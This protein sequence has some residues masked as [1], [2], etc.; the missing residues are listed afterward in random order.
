[1]RICIAPPP[2]PALRRPL[3]EPPAHTHLLGTDAIMSD[4]SDKKPQEAHKQLHRRG[5]LRRARVRWQERAA[6]P[7][8]RPAAS[9]RR[10]PARRRVLGWSDRHHDHRARCGRSTGS[11]MGHLPLCI[12][13][14][15]HRP[16]ARRARLG[17][18]NAGGVLDWPTNPP[19]SRAANLSHGPPH[20]STRLPESS[21][22]HIGF[23]RSPTGARTA[24]LYIRTL[25]SSS[26]T[27]GCFCRSCSSSVC[28]SIVFAVKIMPALDKVGLVT[29]FLGCFVLSITSLPAHPPTNPPSSSL[30]SIQCDRMEVQRFSPGALVRWLP[31]ALLFSRLAQSSLR[32]DDRARKERAQGHGL[33]GAHR[34]RHGSLCHASALCFRSSTLT[35]SSVA[36]PACLISRSSRTPRDQRCHCGAFRSL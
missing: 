26:G 18:P 14:P 16:L 15:L 36:L 31:R 19:P 29:F 30:S 8:V 35:A 6:H 25:S 27:P 9:S 13:H 10:R 11:L 2:R 22:P 4:T 21:P 1:M 34:H 24:V 32:G 12:L 20:G 5:Q 28:S 3:L 33:L 17:L 7:T 23:A